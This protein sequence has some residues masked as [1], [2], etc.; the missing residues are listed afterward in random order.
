MPRENAHADTPDLKQKRRTE[1]TITARY[2]RNWEKSKLTPITSEQ[3]RIILDRFSTEPDPYVWSEQD[4]E[5]Q[6][7]NF[8][9]CGCWEKPMISHAEQ[10]DLLFDD[11]MLF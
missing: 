3:K 11:E 7:R 1:M 2:L 8:L 9:N 5:I 10:S 4:I 6:I